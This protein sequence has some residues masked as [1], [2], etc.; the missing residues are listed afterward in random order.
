MRGAITYNDIMFKLT[1][2]DKEVISTIISENI[3]QTAKTR[4]PFI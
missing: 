4:L 1:A 2:D 3:E